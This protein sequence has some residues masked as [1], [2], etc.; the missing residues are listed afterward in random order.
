MKSKFIILILL[1]VLTATLYIACDRSPV[2]SQDDPPEAELISLNRGDWTKSSK[3]AGLD[4]TNPL[5]KLIWY[6]PYSLTPSDEIWDS[7]TQVG[8]SATNTFW[9]EYNPSDTGTV[10]GSWAGIMQSVRIA[11][12]REDTAQYLE[13]C[14]YGNRGIIHIDMGSISEDIN[15]NGMLDT[16]DKQDPYSLISNGIIDQGED[17]GLDGLFDNDEPGYDE[18]NNPDPNGD[19]WYYNG[20]GIIGNNDDGGVYDYSH[21][22]GTEGNAYDPTKYGRPDTEDLDNDAGLDSQNSYVSYKIDLEETDFFVSG[23]NYN[24]WKTYRIPLNDSLL[25]DTIINPGDFPFP[26]GSRLLYVRIW[27]ESQSDEPFEIGIAAVD[28]VGFKEPGEMGFIPKEYT[29]RD[30]QYAYGRI[31]DLGRT[32]YNH[33]EPSEYD[34]IP[35]D[36]IIYIEVYKSGRIGPD[37]DPAAPYADLYVDLDDTSNYVNENAKTKVHQIGPTEYVIHPTEHWIL[38]NTAN[39][40][41]QD[42]IGYFMIVKR[43]SGKIDT[44]GSVTEEP[45]Q[46]KLLRNNNVLPSFVTWNYEWRNVYSLQRQIMDLKSLEINIY[47]GGIGTENSGENLDHQNGVKYIK[48][49]GLDR[50]DRNGNRVPDGLVDVYSTIVDPY[51]GLLFFPDR[52]PFASA[53]EFV[54]GVVLDPQVNEI[55]DLPYGHSTLIQSTKYYIKLNYLIYDYIK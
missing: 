13:L 33:D 12:A 3:P 53:T 1:I 31:F 2:D 48:I 4:Q 55:Y 37:P 8:A 17:C 23:S 52:K 36:S 18:M 26:I 29:I 41:S 39:G 40:G 46:L 10:S 30:F 34:F 32:V 21:I 28:F 5:G 51:R 49:L 43:A 15:G 22:N 16:E 25:A 19:N 20:W 47:K 6:N 9:M 27:L 45:Y 42:L 14:M 44:V 7:E 35:G 11:L 50:F 54:E 38:F 24:G